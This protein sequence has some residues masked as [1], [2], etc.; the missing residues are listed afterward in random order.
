MVYNSERDTSNPFLFRVRDKWDE[1]VEFEGKTIIEKVVKSISILIVLCALILLIPV[2]IILSIYNSFYN[3]Q[4]K[5]YDAIR[6]N[7]E[8]SNSEFAASV[9]YG[10][11]IVLSLPFFLLLMPYWIFSVLFTWLI[12]HKW[13]ATIVI[14]MII[15]LVLFR[16]E[17]FRICRLYMTE[18]L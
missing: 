1:L 7:S 9:E 3:L 6:F 8:S 13:I 16:E 18:V 2:G 17:V 12:K 15:L 14:I 5:T 4:K 10:I 11:Y